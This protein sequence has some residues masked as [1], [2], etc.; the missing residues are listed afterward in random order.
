MIQSFYESESSEN[1]DVDIC[2]YDDR[3]FDWL[4][5]PILA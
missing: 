3:Q 4:V 2:Q 5:C 1:I